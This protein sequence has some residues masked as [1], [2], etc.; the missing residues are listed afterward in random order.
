MNQKLPKPVLDALARQSPPAEHPSADGLTAFTENALAGNEYRRI[1]AH[2]ARC[3]QCREVVFLAVGA[4]DRPLQIEEQVAAAYRPRRRWMLRLVWGASIA[5]C[6]LVIA[7]ALMLWRRESAPAQMEMASRAV[8]IP[9]AQPTEPA[10][11]AQ[12]ATA[13]QTMAEIAAAPPVSKPAAKTARANTLSPKGAETPGMGA[14]AGIVAGTVPQPG[15]AAPPTTVAAAR[16]AP[17]ITNAEPTTIT[18]GNAAPTMAPATP[19]VNSFAAAQGGPLAGAAPG[20]ADKL[21]LSPQSTARAMRAA[22]PQWRITADG[23]LEHLTA[24]GWTRALPNEAAN[25]RVVSVVGNQVWVGGS[26]GALFHS[27]DEGQNWQEVALT[28]PNGRETATIVS[29]QFDDP[30]HGAVTTDTGTRCSTTDGGASWS[31]Q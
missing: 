27:R 28:T 26:N 13:P 18:I 17:S 3:G 24:E 30:Q 5:A 7:S 20:S 29:I 12:P 6:V 2:L 9:A 22:H 8:G 16:A 10:Q 19:H 11:S 15:K 14:S 1:A 4:T 25:F 21:L 31:C 23:H